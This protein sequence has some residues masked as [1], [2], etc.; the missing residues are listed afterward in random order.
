MNNII[1]D[2]IIFSLQNTGGISV[3]WYE[4]IKRILNDTENFDTYFIEYRNQN[5]FRQQLPIPL[6]KVVHKSPFFLTFR[7]YLNPCIK[8]NG[9]FVFH[10]S[11]Y[12]TAKCKNAINIT[13]VHDFTYEY[14]RHDTRSILHKIQKKNAVYNSA[15]VICVSRNTKDDLLKLY[16]NY[17]GHIKVVYNGCSVDYLPLNISKKDTVIFIG[18]RNGYKGF[19]Y[20]VKIMQKLPH[21]A[22]QIIGGGDL[23]KEEIQLLNRYIPNKYEYYPKLSNN[24]LN[25]KYNEAQF[26][27][28][29]SLY[30]GFGIPV[31]EAQ[32][33]GCPVV[34]CNTSSLPEVGGDSAIFISGKNIDDDIAKIMQLN[35]QAYYK[36]IQERGYS[37]SKRFSWEKC[38]AET[39]DFYQEIFNLKEGA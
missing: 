36:D 13:T 9:K 23:R 26:L 29:P 32:A 15:G 18:G 33:A 21:L 17:K 8:G 30:E 28:Y 7:R 10:S 12:R 16:P 14:F 2:N 3:V 25:I 37:N 5:I 11:Y 4:L 38:A 22:L 20:A 35:N 39:Y 1:L 31:V 24:E 27:L 34:C 6:N 19:D